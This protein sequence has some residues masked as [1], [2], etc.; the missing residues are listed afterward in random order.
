LGKLDANRDHLAGYE[1]SVA[2]LAQS[3]YDETKSFDENKDALL[4]AVKAKSSWQGLLAF[5]A[6]SVG[7]CYSLASVCA[8]LFNS[9]P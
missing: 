2:E 8:M 3:V 7:S 1:E 9:L 6:L 4:A 5:A